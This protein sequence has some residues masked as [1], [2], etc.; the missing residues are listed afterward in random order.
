V[1]GTAEFSAT[2]GRQTLQDGEAMPVARASEC[3]AYFQQPTAPHPPDILLR[4][5]LRENSAASDPPT[6]DTLESTFGM[7]AGRWRK[8][9]LK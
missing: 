6:A 3:G 7:L 8:R 9:R 1:I 4:T 5:P 2:G